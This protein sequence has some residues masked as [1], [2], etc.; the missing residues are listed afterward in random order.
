MLGKAI[1]ASSPCYIKIESLPLEWQESLFNINAKSDL[2]KI[3]GLL[4][5]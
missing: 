4:R 5:V 2:K 1:R 3:K